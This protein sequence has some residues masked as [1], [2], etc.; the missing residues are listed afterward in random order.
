MATIAEQLNQ[1]SINKLKAFLADEIDE[2]KIATS[3]TKG[4][5]E[6]LRKTFG[7]D[8]IKVNGTGIDIAYKILSD[9]DSPVKFFDMKP[10]FAQ[11]SKAKPTKDGGWYLRVPIGNLA[12]TYRQ[13]Y[14]RKQFDLISH[15]QIGETAGE[16]ANRER[17]QRILSNAGGLNGT[18]LGYQWKGTS[19]TKVPSSNGGG[20]GSYI[21]F[22]T[23]SNK[24]DPNSWINS[25]NSMANAIT[26]NTE[27][28]Q[29]AKL[30]ANIIG[31]AVDR[32][33]SNYKGGD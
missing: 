26:N 5:A 25:R 9:E 11:S 12:K 1:E 28:E 2:H 7:N 16:N 17:F 15:I 29:E 4:L 27:T 3:F 23:V 20:R 19:V 33:V 13:A 21:S 30:V 31:K 10:Y 22:R 24:S 8:T 6:D 14:G 18:A 32:V